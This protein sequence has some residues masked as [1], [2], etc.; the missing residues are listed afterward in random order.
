MIYN[1]SNHNLS[2]LPKD[3]NRFFFR[4]MACFIPLTKESATGLGKVNYNYRLIYKA[5][6]SKAQRPNCK[7]G[8]LPTELYPLMN[9]GTDSNQN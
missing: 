5:S 6:F 9:N 7:G 3:K 1:R 4:I 8:A 2:N